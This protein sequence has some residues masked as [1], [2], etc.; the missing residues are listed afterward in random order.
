MYGEVD[1]SP[2]KTYMIDHRD[3]PDVKTLFRLAF[4]KRPAEELY[5]LHKDPGQLNN[6]AGRPDYAE[7]QRELV[8][9]FEREFTAVY[10]PSTLGIP[11]R[12]A[13]TRNF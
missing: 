9:I 2:T 4:E 7:H 10:D 12:P 3:D 6:V 11:P 1:P 8:A 5:D 13:S